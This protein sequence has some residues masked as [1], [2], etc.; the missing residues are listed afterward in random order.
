MAEQREQ[1]DERNQ[2]DQFYE[3]MPG[4]MSQTPARHDGDY[5]E[6]QDFEEYE[7]S[8]I[9]PWV[10]VAVVVI[11]LGLLLMAGLSMPR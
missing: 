5:I 11:L 8:G 6:D 1:P 10:L 2:D 4:A 9:L 3:A 7:R